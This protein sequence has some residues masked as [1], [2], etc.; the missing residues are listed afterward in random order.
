MS[1]DSSDYDTDDHL[2]QDYKILQDTKRKDFFFISHPLRTVVAVEDGAIYH[3]HV[4]PEH[5]YNLLKQDDE[6]SDPETIR[7]FICSPIHQ[8]DSPLR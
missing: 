1:S 8:A 3:V 6:D 2:K 4:S 7:C 5:L